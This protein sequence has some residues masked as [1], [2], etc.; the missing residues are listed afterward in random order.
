MRIPGIVDWRPDF[1][2][3]A[4]VLSIAGTRTY[5][6]EMDA[7]EQRLF[8]PGDGALPPSL[9]GREQEQTLLNRCLADLTGGGSPPYNV[10]LI[11]P[12]GNGKTVLLRW[13]EDA[14][15][16]A[17]VNVVRIAPSRA[18]TGQALCN[19][20]LPATGLGRLL[21]VKKWGIEGVGKAEWEASSPP[22]T[23]SWTGSSPGAA[24]SRWP[25]WWTKRIRWTSTSASSC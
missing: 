16:K 5:T 20:L 17:R 6:A 23:T 13:F 11:G 4:P 14:C 15:R 7:T 22:C 2:M 1:L 19:A 10:A 3:P 25:R 18:R 12:R 24:R 9:A 8:A 21:P